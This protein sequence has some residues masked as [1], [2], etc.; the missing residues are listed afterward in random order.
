MVEFITVYDMSGE[1]AYQWLLDLH[2]SCSS[3]GN[4]AKGVFVPSEEGVHV[5]EEI[6]R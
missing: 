3:F 1:E 2:D 6:Q 5:D 4:F